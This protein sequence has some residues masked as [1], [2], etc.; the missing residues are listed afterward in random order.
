LFEI[1]Q[2][3]G[4]RHPD[5]RAMTKLLLID[6]NVLGIG[7]MREYAYR[8]RSHHG[9][10]TGAIHGTLDKLQSL[11][12][13]HGDHLPLV[14]WDDRCRWHEAIL[15]MYKRHRWA[16][17]EQQ[18][19]LKSYLEQA[20]VVRQLVAHLGLPQASCPDFEADDLAGLIC[21]G[22]DPAW[23]IILVTSDTDWYQALRENVTWQSPRTGKTIR[24]HDLGNVDLIEEGPFDSVDHYVCAKALAGDASDGIPGVKGVGLK[25]AARIIREHG[26]VDALW[27][28]HDA[29][30]R[31]RGVALRRAAGPECRADYVRNLK[32][33]DWRLAPP[34]RSDFEV[35]HSPSEI[36]AFVELCE[37]WGMSGVGEAWR[38]CRGPGQG[39]DVAMARV[40]AI[41]EDAVG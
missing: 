20:V 1:K 16:T 27:A 19:F 7:A 18:A 30:E 22:A 3:A 13:R 15:P 41:L 10:A 2:W 34:L 28:R 12:E 33:I 25:T 39:A 29:G 26:S 23:E 24:A 36:P 11:V 17:P 35:E 31:L 8:D 6:I 4:N 37:A 14:L 32:L 5:P 9:K 38:R 21:R 40:R